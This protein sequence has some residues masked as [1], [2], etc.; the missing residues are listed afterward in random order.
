MAQFF[1]PQDPNMYS[2]IGQ[3][4]GAGLGGVGQYAVNAYQRPQNLQKLIQGGA[5]PAEAE[6]LVDMPPAQQMQFFTQKMK[7]SREDAQNAALAN[8]LG[9]PKPGAQNQPVAND[10]ASLDKNLSGLGDSAPDL[11]NKEK[12]NAAA[13]VVGYDLNKMEK[14]DKMLAREDEAKAKQ[15]ERQEARTERQEKLQRKDIHE[16]TKKWKEESKKADKNLHAFEELRILGEDQE[17][18]TPTLLRKF[19][20]K[21]GFGSYF[22]GEKEEAYGKIT[23]GLIMDKA[24]ELASAGKITAAIFDRVRMRYPSLEN[25]PEGRNLLV[26]ILGREEIEKKV[27]N[28][29]Y[30]QLRKEG[31]W[32]KG[33][34]PIDILEQVDEIADPIL[35]QMREEANEALKKDIGYTESD[36]AVDQLNEQPLPQGMQEGMIARNKDTGQP[37]A[38]FKNGKWQPI[39][40]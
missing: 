22:Q 11:T 18:F 19:I 1:G 27:Y 8:I 10:N 3:I 12:R 35:A 31:G 15:S 6:M 28:N 29:I 16:T 13:A 25:T 26:N 14:I 9:I 40:G 2:D 21:A 32:K 33:S 4:L 24:A 23:E 17:A 34:E 30:N 5:T 39:E 7:Q 36:E 37:M 38:Q 20:T